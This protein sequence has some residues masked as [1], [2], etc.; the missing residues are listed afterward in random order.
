M[1]EPT[2]CN[3]CGKPGHVFHQCKLPITSIGIIA[4]RK[5]EG[6]IQY[7]MIRRKDTLGF[8]DFM[9]GKYAVNN[10]YYIINMLKQM[11]Q[12]E[13]EILKLGDFD[14][15][16]FKLWVGNVISNQYK[17]EESISRE[18]YNSLV[19]VILVKEDFYTL[20][21]L[22]EESNKGKL[23]TEAEWGFPKGRR[24]FQETDL[25]CAI[26]EFEE[27]TGFKRDNMTLI[28]NVLPFEEIFTGSN[29][30][31]YKHKYFLTFMN[32]ADTLEMD[33]FE[34]AEVSQMEWLSYNDCTLKI[35]EY[36]V[37]KKT[38]LNKV[39]ECLMKFSIAQ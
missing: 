9:R 5:I 10:K 36:N 16:W 28:Q 27:E 11:T 39:N 24:N 21:D 20:G 14:A 35:R 7:L 25:N 30:K 23:W 22:I 18:I 29:Y 12:E 2:Y 31:S 6:Q 13:K 32:H 37:E 34:R 1:Q 19:Q 4:F 3:N 33:N 15:V 17:N 26:R 8:I 38:L